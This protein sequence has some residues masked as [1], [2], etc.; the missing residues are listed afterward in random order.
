M[1]EADHILWAC[2]DLDQGAA[3]IAALTG[4]SP[5]RG[6]SHPGFGT[7]NNL[8]SFGQTYLEIIA[9]DPEQ[10]L[11]DNWGAAI[12]A[13]AQPGLWTFA[14]RTTDLA[15][16]GAAAARAGLAVRGPVAMSRQRPDGVRLD[17]ACLYPEH[18]IYGEAIPFA[19]DWRG[20]PH[21]AATAPAGCR[22]IDFAV[23]HP[24]PAPLA[25]LYAALGVDIAVRHAARP[26]LLARLATPRG[27]AVLLG[28]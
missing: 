9:P 3:T 21:P 2:P 14:V 1:N 7:R 19:I 25:R 22:L 26:G 11:R 20:S 4:V 10:P 15:A 24:D 17:W 28:P 27:E 18:A 6:G 13:R 8:L 12:A 5:S 16:Y 23:L